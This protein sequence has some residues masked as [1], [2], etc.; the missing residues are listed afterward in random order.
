MRRNVS[1]NSINL[2]KEKKRPRGVFLRVDSAHLR[3]VKLLVEEDRS[4]W[5]IHREQPIDRAAQVENIIEEIDD[6]C[7]ASRLR[8]G[9][10]SELLRTGMDVKCLDSIGDHLNQ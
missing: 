5:S 1:D 10:G 9:A 3:Q 4:T 2:I 6:V 7:R 8:C